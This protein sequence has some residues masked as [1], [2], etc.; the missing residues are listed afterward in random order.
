M[1][2]F[3]ESVLLGKEPKNKIDDLHICLLDNF[4]EFNNY[5]WGRLSFEATMLSLKNTV[6]KRSK[7]IGSLDPNTKEK[8]NLYDFSFAFQVWTYEV[9]SEF[10]QKFATENSDLKVPRILKW[11]CKNKI[12][13]DVINKALKEE[14]T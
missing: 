5:P 9:I 13:V 12:M 6:T 7:R 10:G 4:K 14:D 8:Y 1:L 11:F 3:F 2:Y